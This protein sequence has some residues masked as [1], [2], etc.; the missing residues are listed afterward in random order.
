MMTGERL[1]MRDAKRLELVQVPGPEGVR[2]ENLSEEEIEA[3][4]SRE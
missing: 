1:F 3:I 2:G 4:K